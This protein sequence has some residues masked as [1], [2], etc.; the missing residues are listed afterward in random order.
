MFILLGM[1]CVKEGYYSYLLFVRILRER[2]WK[3]RHEYSIIG[4]LSSVQ[5]LPETGCIKNYFKKWKSNVSGWPNS[6][7]IYLVI[8]IKDILSNT[9]VILNIKLHTKK[10]LDMLTFWLFNSLQIIF[11]W[12]IPFSNSFS[13][14]VIKNSKIP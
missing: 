13:V 8:Y 2:E 5:P 1:S 3:S 12:F 7:W 6:I 9:N 4:C 14:W 11:K 10:D